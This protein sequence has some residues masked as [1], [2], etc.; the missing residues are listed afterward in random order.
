MMDI[1][2]AQVLECFSDVLF[3]V[4]FFPRSLVGVLHV[5]YQEEL[6]ARYT[7]KFYFV[8]KKSLNGLMYI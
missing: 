1:T 6:L 7:M 2:V 3:V 4:F 5:D 8:Q